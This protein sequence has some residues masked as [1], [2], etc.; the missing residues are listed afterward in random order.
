MKA[1][2]PFSFHSDGNTS[3]TKINDFLRLLLRH[4]LH[5]LSCYHPHHLVQDLHPVYTL[6][7][8]FDFIPVTDTFR[9]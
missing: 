2:S 3:R 1:F 5:F 4:D 9:M 7:T 6:P 8:F